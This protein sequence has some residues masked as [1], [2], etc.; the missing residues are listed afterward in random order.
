MVYSC[1]FRQIIV[2]YSNYCGVHCEYDTD[3]WPPGAATDSTIFVT[4]NNIEPGGADGHTGPQWSSLS[5]LFSKE[6]LL[7]SERGADKNQILERA[8]IFFVTI[9]SAF[10]VNPN[11]TTLGT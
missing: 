8:A 10:L 9:F 5:M 11:L 2:E 4:G 3:V 1:L 7:H 6:M